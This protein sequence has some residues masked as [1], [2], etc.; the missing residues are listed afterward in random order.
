MAQLPLDGVER[1]TLAGELKRMRVAELVRFEPAPHPR[2][3]GEAAELDP[4]SGGRPGSPVPSPEHLRL[5]WSWLGARVVLGE[6]LQRLRVL[7]DHALADRAD[8]LAQLLSRQD[9]KLAAAQ[10]LDEH[11][12][13]RR[14][15]MRLELAGDRNHVAVADATDLYDL[16]EREYTRGYPKCR[17][18]R[19]G[20]RIRQPKRESRVHAWA[21]A[22]MSASR[23][24]K[25]RD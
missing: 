13:A 15:A 9:P 8:P 18:H 25:L 19:R 24:M 21:E 16:H 6:N 3:G 10:L 17:W 22:Q 11:G 12:R 23:G 20:F 7:G 1:H 4:D 2:S 5:L 14:I